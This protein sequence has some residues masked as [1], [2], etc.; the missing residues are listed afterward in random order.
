[1]AG[2]SLHYKI[3]SHTVSAY[4]GVSHSKAPWST[5]CCRIT[6][7]SIPNCKILPW[8][9]LGLKARQRFRPSSSPLKSMTT[10]EHNSLFIKSSSVLRTQILLS[11][12]LFCR[13]T[14]KVILKPAHQGQAIASSLAESTLSHSVYV[15]VGAKDALRDGKHSNISRFLQKQCNRCS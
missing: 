6:N 13:E 14:A 3:S 11:L 4:C 15:T 10:E 2:L 12:K 8:V 1:M 5:I 7:G 9:L